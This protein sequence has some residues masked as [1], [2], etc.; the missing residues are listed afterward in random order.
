M[1]SDRHDVTGWTPVAEVAQRLGTTPL[2]V[3]MHIKRGLLVGIEQEGGWL[4]DPESL[5]AL[6]GKRAAGEL[7]AVCQSG[8]SKKAG[9]CG[10]CS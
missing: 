1:K 10:S 7:P 6:L 5:A 9:G 3:L 2:N 4:V 8:C